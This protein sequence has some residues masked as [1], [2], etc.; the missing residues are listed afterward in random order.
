MNSLFFL[1]GPLQ[2]SHDPYPYYGESIIFLFLT[3]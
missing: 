3:R 2:W 1:Q